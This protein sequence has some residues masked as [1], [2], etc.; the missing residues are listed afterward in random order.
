VTAV[1]PAIAKV[2][3]SDPCRLPMPARAAAAAILEPELD[4]APVGGGTELARGRARRGC[5]RWW[6]N[7]V[8]YHEVPNSRLVCREN[9]ELRSF[10]VASMISWRG[11]S[12]MVDLGAIVRGRRSGS[13]A[14]RARAREHRW[15]R[16]PA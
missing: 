16:L 11:V 15:G 10:E 8:G 12:S 1:S 7:R 3:L 5:P 13:S 2:L 6:V 14:I 4:A 9:G